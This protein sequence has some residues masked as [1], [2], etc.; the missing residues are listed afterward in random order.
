[1]E[2][3][4]RVSSLNQECRKSKVP[5]NYQRH[6]ATDQDAE[7]GPHR[8]ES[9]TP[10]KRKTEISNLSAGTDQVR[11]LRAAPAVVVYRNIRRP[12]TLHQRLESNFDE[13]T[14]PRS[15]ALTACIG[16]GK[17]PGVVAGDRNATDIDRGCRTIR[18]IIS[19]P[20]VV[21]MQPHSVKLGVRP[22]LLLECKFWLEDDGWNATI[23]SLGLTVQAR[24]G[25]RN[26]RDGRDSAAARGEAWAGRSRGG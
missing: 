1:V 4:L 20:G 8:C 7:A 14:R 19:W 23:E 16:F 5:S 12:F 2:V 25:R 13:A 22:C 9:R 3:S 6:S 15:H 26:F 18:S 24:F 10:F 11:L 17:V 21:S